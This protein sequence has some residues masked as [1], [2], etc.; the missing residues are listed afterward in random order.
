MK[1]I[2]IGRNYTEHIAELNNSVPDQPVIF[3]KPDTAL[4]KDNQPFYHPAH[5]QNIHHE[6]ELVLRIG[7]TGKNIEPDFAH[8]YIDSITVGIDFTARDTQEYLKKNGLPW[9]LAKGFDGSA[10]IGSFLPF[11]EV[12]H[13]G[14]GVGFKLLKNNEE[15]Q[16]GNSNLMIHNFA[17]IISFVSKYFTLKTGD[18]IFTGTPKGVSKVSIGDKL[19]AFIGDRCLLITEVM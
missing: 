19:E 12:Y 7:K 1:I 4:I 3:L 11:Q 13:A 16:N 14:K 18:V 9:E 17:A 2:C 6:L 15:V 10:P 5:S 8:R